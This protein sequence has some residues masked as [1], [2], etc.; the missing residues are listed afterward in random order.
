MSLGDSQNEVTGS[1]GSNCF[2][3]WRVWKDAECLGLFPKKDPEVRPGEVEE[4]V[5]YRTSAHFSLIWK[6]PNITKARVH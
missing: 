1:F 6:I 3:Q 5:G 2:L 4:R